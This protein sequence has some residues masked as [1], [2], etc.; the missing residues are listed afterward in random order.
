MK[1]VLTGCGIVS[2]AARIV[3]LVAVSAVSLFAQ[4]GPAPIVKQQY[5]NN[6]GQPLANGTV[7]TFLSGT[8]TPSAT[9]T[10]YTLSVANPQCVPLDSAGR[11]S[12]WIGSIIYRFV[13]KDSVGVTIWTQDGIAVAAPGA[14]GAAAWTVVGITIYSTPTNYSVCVGCTTALAKFNVNG[15][16]SGFNYLMRI[17]D[18]GNSPGISLYASGNSVGAYTADSTGLRL[19]AASGSPQVTVSQGNVTI[20]D[21][22]ATGATVLTLKEGTSQ[23]SANPI[24][25]QNNAGT[26]LSWIDSAG[27]FVSPLLNSTAT[28]AAIA[29]QTNTSTFSVNG[30]G[31]ISTNGQINIVGT[32][33]PTNGGGNVALKINGAEV[34]DNTGNATF[35]TLTCTGTPCGSGGGGGGGLPVSDATNIVFAAGDATKRL[36]FDVGGFTTA[37]IRT[38]TWPDANITV[39]GVENAQ[40]VTG[41]KVFSAIVTGNAGF[42][43]TNYNSTNTGSAFTFQNANSNFLVN[44]NG[45]VTANGNVVATGF[46]SAVGAVSSDAFHGMKC[47]NGTPPSTP[48]AGYSGLTYRG[49]TTNCTTGGS[50][51]HVWLYDTVHSAW[52]D[53]DLGGVGGTGITSVNG[54]TGAAQ[55]IAGTANRIVA[56]TTTNTVTLST[57]QDINTSSSPTFNNITASGSLL[58]NGSIA[59]QNA[60][61]SF[62]VLNTGYVKGGL[63]DS[64]NPGSTY[65]YRVDGTTVIDSARNATFNNVTIGGVCTGC[66]G[67][68]GGGVTSAT[69]TANQVLVN[70]G[71][72]T[73][74]GAVTFSLPQAIGTA[75]SPTFSNVTANGSFLANGAIAIQNATV[76]F[77][78]LNT[79]SVKGGLFNS[80]NPGSTYGYQVD[81]SM[82]INSSRQFVGTGVDVGGGGISSGNYNLQGGFLGQTFNVFIPGMSISGVPT[83]NTGLVFRGGIVVSCFDI[84]GGALQFFAMWLFGLVYL[85]FRKYVLPRFPTN[86]AGNIQL[87]NAEF[88]GN[89]LLAIRSRIVH[90]PYAKH[91]FACQ[92]SRMLGLSTCQ[93]FW[94]QSGSVPIS[95]CGCFGMSISSVPFSSCGPLGVNSE[96]RSVTL[97]GPSSV[98]SVLNIFL[99]ATPSPMRRVLAWRIVARMQ[100]QIRKWI[101]SRINL[102]ANPD[103]PDRFISQFHFPVSILIGTASPWPAFVWPS[104]VN[105]VPIS[106]NCVSREFGEWFRMVPGHC[107]LLAR[108]RAWPS[109]ASNTGGLFYSTANPSAIL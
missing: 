20:Q 91:L 47:V 74:T 10:D 58:A 73:Q 62:E 28:A 21:T 11:A 90:L 50:G 44:G 109:G 35:T 48:S 3:F 107:D 77:E 18:A 96:S 6:N 41:A 2:L 40:T 104:L 22:S 67:G 13:L 5:F 61:V 49:G 53:I 108:L 98:L 72:G 52:T 84:Y 82:V 43:G 75:S 101:I 100:N 31:D 56:T 106:L 94:M 81:G 54:Q 93:P 99:K 16:S 24:Q 46:A 102:P 79:G 12:I 51:L 65:G 92:F 70:G 105:F 27:R 30:Y 7:C 95:P 68:G 69:G 60:A 78:V 86:D 85:G 23:G 25:I 33:D 88:V 83:C 97:R 39:M 76:S 80:A 15:T 38:A 87:T 55:T 64:V 37:T 45:D 19:R 34:I 1:V 103:R 89:L 57:P 26:N 36:K 4:G 17:D 32:N 66:G 63:F 9:F 71:T 42:S 8:T 14:S 59:I 29:F